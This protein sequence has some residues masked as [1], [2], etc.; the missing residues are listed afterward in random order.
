ML[1]V[2]YDISSDSLRSRFSKFL[3]KYGNRIQYSLFEVRNSERVLTNIKV[4][5]ESTF[6]KQ[7]SQSDSVYIFK[8]SQTCRTIKYGYAKNEDSDMIII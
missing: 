8:L 1:L 6:E 4:Q 5:I 7:F 2:S 3:E